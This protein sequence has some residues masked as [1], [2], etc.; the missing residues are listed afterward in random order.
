MPPVKPHDPKIFQGA[1]RRRMLTRVVQARRHLETLPQG[2]GRAW[3]NGREVGGAD[4]RFGHL[5]RI[6]D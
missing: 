2:A 1:T 6:H 3:I 5:A 4:L